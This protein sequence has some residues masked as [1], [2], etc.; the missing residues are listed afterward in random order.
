[1]AIVSPIEALPTELLWSIAFDARV[2]APCEVLA[3]SLSSR[4]MWARLLGDDGGKMRTRALMGGAWCTERQM[5]RAAR[6]AVAACGDAIPLYAGW[7][8]GECAAEYEF[9]EIDPCSNLIWHVLGEMFSMPGPGSAGDDRNEWLALMRELVKVP[10]FVRAESSHFDEDCSM[11]FWRHPLDYLAALGDVDAV[12]L[13]LAHSET[14]VH[15][16]DHSAVRIACLYG[17]VDVAHRLLEAVPTGPCFDGGRVL[18]TVATQASCELAAALLRAGTAS[19]SDLATAVEMAASGGNVAVLALL[20]DRDDV[21]ISD[22]GGS[23][24][25]RAA[26]NGMLAAVQMLLAHAHGAHISDLALGEAVASRRT[27]VVAALLADGRISVSPSMASTL[28]EV[29]PD[30]ML[31]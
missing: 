27:A 2:L 19:A 22:D 17:H 28:A 16:H 12:E 14:D 3:L 21:A 26:R 11:M 9:E 6:H 29:S 13:A 20:L 30:T 5:W 31:A 8:A 1:M 25:A 7:E 18:A 23:A 4:R 24:L 10:G 15:A